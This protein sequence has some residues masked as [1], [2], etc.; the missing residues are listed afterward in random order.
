LQTERSAAAA[1]RKRFAA[2]TLVGV[3]QPIDRIAADARCTIEAWITRDEDL[4]TVASGYLY[5]QLSTAGYGAKVVHGYLVCDRPHVSLRDPFFDAGRPAGHVIQE[6]H[7]WVVVDDVL[8]DIT[9]SQ[10]NDQL[11]EKFEP[12]TIGRANEMRRHIGAV[13]VPPFVPERG[14]DWPAVFRRKCAE[15][16]SRMGHPQID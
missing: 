7:T 4:C 16:D 3:R 2:N 9:A 14:E 6:Q 1:S 8:I 15:R 12:V 5:S 13:E 11:D 10:F